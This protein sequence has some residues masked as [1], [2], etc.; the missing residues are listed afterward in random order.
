MKKK[1]SFIRIHSITLLSV[2]VLTL[3]TVGCANNVTPA[4]PPIQD[5]GTKNAKTDKTII[6]SDRLMAKMEKNQL[7]NESH[8]IVAGTVLSQE[9]TKDFTGFPV[10]DTQIQVEHV[11]KGKAASTVEV[12]VAGGET[13]DMI[14]EV[15]EDAGPTFEIGERVVVFLSDNKG[16]IPDP[17]SFG[18]FVVGQGQG[19]FRIEQGTA[20]EEGSEKNIENSAGT[21]TFDFGNLQ[22]EIEQ[23]EQY[24][25]THNVPRL[26][27]PQGE[28]SGI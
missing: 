25:R 13:E 27:L 12:R 5:N 26:M 8:L 6:Q 17:D 28:E 15:S 22:Q 10:T 19:K 11:Y 3:L 4:N 14:Y 23:L 21:R 16:K 24:N 18:Y 9:V 1:V 20:I 2:I 7:V